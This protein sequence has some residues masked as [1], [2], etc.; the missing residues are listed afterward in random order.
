MRARKEVAVS[1]GFN[2]SYTSDEKKW[3][4]NPTAEG[5]LERKPQ[6]F[7]VPVVTLI[8]YYDPVGE[9]QSYIYPG[10]AWRLW[11]LPSR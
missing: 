10:A 11:L 1:R 2:K 4:E 6:Y 9:K 8:G 5:G 7:G 3:I